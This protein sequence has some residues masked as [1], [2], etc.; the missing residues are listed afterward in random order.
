[1]LCGEDLEGVLCN[2]IVMILSLGVYERIVVIVR[3]YRMLE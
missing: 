2:V 3:K 1:M